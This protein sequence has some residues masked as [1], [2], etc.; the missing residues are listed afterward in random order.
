[1]T[2]NSI[3]PAVKNDQQANLG[4]DSK[5]PEGRDENG[6]VLVAALTQALQHSSLLSKR[7]LR[8]SRTTTT[9]VIITMFVTFA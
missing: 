2:L 8:T 7:L 4:P 6:M 3:N 1:M 5:L 9:L